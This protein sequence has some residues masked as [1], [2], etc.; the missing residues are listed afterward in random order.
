MISNFSTRLVVALLAP[1]GVVA[2]LL[3]Q[4]KV[5]TVYSSR[6]HYGSEPVFEQFT[7]ETG[8][9]I[10]FFSGNNNEVI[11]RLRAEGNRTR[12]DVLLTVDAGNL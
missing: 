1:A 9:G 8:I 2:P 3:G 5:L 6:S 12:A 7:R 4:D 10:E 11:E